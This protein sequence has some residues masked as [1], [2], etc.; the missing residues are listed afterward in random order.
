MTAPL[1]AIEG[2]RVAFDGTPVLH[3]VELAVAPGESLGL[4]GESG[5]G[6]SVTWLAA[7]GLLPR[8]ARVAG[9]VRLDGQELLGASPSVLDRVRGGR[10]ATI[11]QDPAS[12]LNP[13]HRV[14]AQVAEAVRLHR[15]LDAAASKAEAVRLLDQV[16]IPDAPRRYGLYP[17]E[18]SGGQNQRVMIA[19]ALAGRPELLVADEPTT[20]LDVTVQAGILDLLRRLRAETGMALVLIS[21]DLGVVAETCDRVLV[22]YAGRIVEEGPSAAVFADPLHP[23]AAGLLAALPDVAGPRRRLQAIPGTLPEPGRLPP[24][25]AFAPRCPRAAPDC[26]AAPPPLDAVRPGRHAAC[27][28]PG[29][30]LRPEASRRP[31]F[32]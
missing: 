17:Y 19:A 4:V 24:G 27:I 16:G 6:K 3:G 31:E 12:A 23:Y 21:H 26:D 10:I 1:V 8:R 20:A 11:P 32:A 25:C 14:G 5:S 15:G 18:M 2:L 13:V 30:V 29:A 9:S 7:L 28:H 22:M